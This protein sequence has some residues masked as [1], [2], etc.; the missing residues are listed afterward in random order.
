[1]MTPT[2]LRAQIMAIHLLLM[3]L[4]SLS[5][6][7]L[8]VAVLTERLFARQSAVGISL[9]LVDSVAACAAALLFLQGRRH[10]K[11]SCAAL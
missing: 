7:P 4:L 1:M 3:N 10:F 6:G 9:S 11:A 2:S 8:I 5:L